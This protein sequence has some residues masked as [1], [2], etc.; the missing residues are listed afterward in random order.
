MV[1]ANENIIVS[2]VHNYKDKTPKSQFSIN[3]PA[4]WVT[5]KI[6]DNEC[7][8]YPFPRTAKQFLENEFIN[9]IMPLTKIEEFKY[10]PRFGLTGLSHVGDYIYAG[11]WNA[12]YEINKSDFS[13][14]RIIS[15]NLMNDLHGIYVNKEYIIT[16]LTGKDTIVFTDFDGKI[17]DHFTINRDLNLTKNSNIEK[18]DWRF[19]SKQFRGANGIWHINHVKKYGNELWL[20]SRNINAIIVVNLKKRK[21]FIKTLDTKTTTMIHDGSKFNKKNYFTSIDGKIIIAE[22]PNNSSSTLRENFK[23]IKKFNRAMIANKVIKLRDSE[24]KREPSWCRGLFAK[25]NHILTTIDGRYEENL[26]KKLDLSFSL[27]CID[28]EG[29]IIF[30]NKFKFFKDK[31]KMRNIRFVTGFDI[32]VL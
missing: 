10:L 28:H 21:A 30:K 8:S 24:L 20:T 16:V 27:L 22:D 6:G 3:A 12:V 4:L 32:L 15:N 1:I 31:S 18:I 17:I 19:L 11:S 25:G 29:K 5:N 2:F 13:L 9:G 26:S 7:Y 14:K 23:E